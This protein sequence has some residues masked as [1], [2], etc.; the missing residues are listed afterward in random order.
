MP[1]DEL[2]I[3]ILMNNS[4]INISEKLEKLTPIITKTEIDE[5]FSEIKN[6]TIS[7]DISK[8]LVEFFNEIKKSDKILYPLSQ[9]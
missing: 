2:Q 6:V 3:N 1:S 5:Y 7:Y 4:S 8:R 9:R